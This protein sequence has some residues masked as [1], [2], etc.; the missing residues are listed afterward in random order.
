MNFGKKHREKGEVF[1]ASLNDIMFFLLLFFLIAS[2]LVSSN[3]I[4]LNLPSAN[5]Q[6]VP[7]KTVDIS[8][9]QD[10]QYYVNKTPVSLELLAVSIES[11]I[12]DNDAAT[13]VIRADKT[14]P[15]EQVVKVMSIVKD[16]NL[17]MVLATEPN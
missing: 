11:A 5:A 14:I 13:V 3:G 9:T 4:N 2:S 15:L 17:K 7:E 1:V 16:M 6:V 12:G 8:I 10:L